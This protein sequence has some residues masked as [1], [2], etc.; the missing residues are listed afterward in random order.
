[1]AGM[2]NECS[3]LFDC[4]IVWL[5]LLRFEIF[6]GSKQVSV[7]LQVILFKGRL[8]GGCKVVMAFRTC[9]VPEGMPLVL[10]QS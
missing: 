3:L 5:V 10:L 4:S 7:E 2:L 1:M 6:L 9:Q 8:N